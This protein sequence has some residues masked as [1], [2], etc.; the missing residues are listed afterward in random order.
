MKRRQHKKL[1]YK[2]VVLLV[3]ASI[4]LSLVG[5]KIERPEDVRRNSIDVMQSDSTNENRSNKEQT[6]KEN[7]FGTDDYL[8]IDDIEAGTKDYSKYETNEDIGEKDSN[9]KND[10]SATT[11]KDNAKNAS[12]NEKEQDTDKST[13]TSNWDHSKDSTNVEFTDS[14]QDGRDDTTGLDKYLTDPVP[15]GMPE[16]IEPEDTIIKKDKTYYCTLSIRCDTILDNRDKLDKELL[17]LLEEDGIKEGVIYPT[18]KVEFYEGESVFD[19]LLRETK[20]EGIHM[21]FSFTPMYNSHYIEGI[22]NFYEFSCGELSGW[23]YRVNGWFP[24]YGCSRYQL[25]DGDVIE[26]VYTCDLGRDVG[27]EWL[28]GTE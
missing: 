19:V 24:N 4:S 10:N 12:K 8:S 27:C 23:M 20:A 13:S 3:L 17:Y 5:C 6:D 7:Y 14:D 1:R 15:E 11:S 26:W 2:I 16:P 18:T 25:K 9:K 22:N 21:E 28:G